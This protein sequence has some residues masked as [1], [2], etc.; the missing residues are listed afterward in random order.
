ARCLVLR[1]VFVFPQVEA[2]GT[3]AEPHPGVALRGGVL[4]RVV[5]AHSIDERPLAGD[6]EEPGGGVPRLRTRGDRPHLHEAEAE[7]EEPFRQAVALVETGG[8]PDRGWKN[9]PAEPNLQA[10]IAKVEASAQAG[11][12]PRDATEPSQHRSGQG[13]GPL[14]LEAEEDALQKSEHV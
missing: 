11:G 12:D 5:E 4:A 9:Q 3:R 13:V 2:E 8:D 6:A 10:R 14:W 7:G 1:R